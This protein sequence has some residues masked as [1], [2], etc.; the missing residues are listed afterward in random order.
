MIYVAYVFG[1]SAMVAL[2]LMG[3]QKSRSRLLV[4]KLIGDCCW[5]GYYLCLGLHKRNVAEVLGGMIP[6]FVGIFRET[7]FFFRDRKK[8]ANSIVFPLVFIAMNW[9]IGIYSFRSPLNV[10]PIA[11]STFVT[12]SL[13]MRNPKFTKIILL[14]VEATFL[15]YNVLIG[16]WVAV[17]NE[18]LSIGSL[19]ISFIKD[20]FFSRSK[21]MYIFTP[22]ITADKQPFLIDGA[23]IENAVGVIRQD[24]A[25]TAVALGEQFAAEIEQNRI[26]DFEKAGDKMAH[27]S[28]FTV[29]GDTVYMS[30]YAN[31]LDADENPEKQTA[32]LAYRKTAGG[33]LTVLD[34]LAAGDTVDGKKVEMVYDTI[35]MRKDD[36]EI[37]LLFTARVAENYY[38]FFRVFDVATKA[39][40][41][42]RVNR[43]MVGKVVNDFSSSGVRA[44]LAVSGI[45]CKKMYSDIGI[46][47]KLSSRI[48]KGVTYYYSGAYSGDFTCIIKS[49]DLVTWEYVSQP[50][51]PNE[52]KWENATYVW[53][54]TVYYFVRQQDACPYGFLTAYDL[55][56]KTW[57]D[58]LLVED[59]QSRGDFIAYGDRL[60]LFHAPLDREHIGMI[61]IDRNDLKNSHTVL[62]AHMHSS[63]FYPFVN[64]YA[65]GKYAVSYTVDRKHIRLATFTIERYIEREN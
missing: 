30:Y 58:P 24:A 21:S 22:D 53:G 25:Q 13:W 46:M 18:S 26:G 42:V 2:F 9:G 48:E 1:G 14:P 11:A 65:D 54:D 19:F 16:A 32:R 33:D 17:V 10:L 8:W 38:R 29:I 55:I 36:K 7:V 50:D 60:F 43:F 45:G 52:S 62:N 28:T 63:C 47:Q 40:G 15:A 41:E 37:Y 61:E 56:S 3:Q 35:L 5:V 39:L 44:A 51:F 12:V 23:P 4:C 20:K 34:L 31:T 57:A 64:T 59:C 49:K 6:N 27:V